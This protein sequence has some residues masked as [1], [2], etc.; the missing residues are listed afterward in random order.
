MCSRR[1]QS[2]AVHG[3]NSC[4]AL[5]CI[6]GCN[7]HKAVC[8][9]CYNSARSV[10]TQCFQVHTAGVVHLTA[11]WLLHSRLVLMCKLHVHRLLMFNCFVF[12]STADGENA[13]PST[14]PAAAAVTPEVEKKQK[15]SVWP[16][17]ALPCTT[18]SFPSHLSSVN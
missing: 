7:Q 2:A 18:D 16:S 9:L 12:F 11:A 14:R 6:C 5:C 1:C 17:L 10:L 13:A 15:V 3:P 4:T 8:R